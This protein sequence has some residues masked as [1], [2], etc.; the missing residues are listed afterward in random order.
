MESSAEVKRKVCRYHLDSG[1]CQ[2]IPPFMCAGEA[3]CTLYQLDAEMLCPNC[4]KKGADWSGWGEHGGFKYTCWNCGHVWTEPLIS[5]LK[6]PGVCL[7]CGRGFTNP[8]PEVT[9]PGSDPEIACKEWC[10]ECN[11]FT[12]NIIRRWSTAYKIDPRKLVDPVRGGGR[13]AGT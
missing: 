2:L 13:H 9:S 5:R 3:D 12:M 7:R 10:A 6:T 11:L 8:V 4:N 1:G